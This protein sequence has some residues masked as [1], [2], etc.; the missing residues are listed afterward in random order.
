MHDPSNTEQTLGNYS[1]L[2]LLGRG[3]TS[4]VYLGEH[5]ELHTQAAIKV[6]RGYWS[7][8]EVQKF[9]ARASVLTYLHHPNIVQVFEFGVE[10]DVAFL[11]MEYAPN[12]SLRQHYPKGT[13]VPLPLIVLY[14][15][16]IAEAL[17]YVHLHKLIHR[18]IK[19]HNMLLSTH[20]RIQLSD[21]GIAVVSQNAYCE[22]F[23]EFEGTIPYAAPEQLL[24]KPCYNSDQ[25]SLGVV[26]Y[27]WLCGTWPFSGSFDE[28]AHQHLF[29]PVPP[30][31][32][33]DAS[34]PAALEEVVLKAL[35]KDPLERFPTILA[36]AEAVEAACQ[37]QPHNAVLQL[38]H[39]SASRQQFK[40]PLPFGD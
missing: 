17:H 14:V 20:G 22:T 8:T 39:P 27:E 37:K 15:Q 7:D 3:M 4:E 16:Q 1:L 38:S 25:Y 13:L 12:G 26:V 10:R 18:D 36:F 29:E 21:F 31:H 2:R 19:P 24:G 6:Q 35:A 28:V 34:I 32:S 40:R 11:A 5:R 33:K 30:L 9:L 23:E